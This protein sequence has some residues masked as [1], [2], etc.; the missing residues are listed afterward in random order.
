MGEEDEG[1][2]LNCR[3][4]RP[5]I[6]NQGLASFP[7]ASENNLQSGREGVTLYRSLRYLRMNENLAAWLVCS[8]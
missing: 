2:T 1:G 3:T 8:S 4:V 5:G 7:S 6:M